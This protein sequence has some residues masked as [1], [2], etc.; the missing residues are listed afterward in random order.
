MLHF[1]MIEDGLGGKLGDFGNPK[2]AKK[3]A[4]RAIGC[5][6]DNLHIINTG[7]GVYWYNSAD[8]DA[9][10]WLAALNPERVVFSGKPAC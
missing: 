9:D 6:P 3:R 1:Y 10:Y 8:N 4:A 7:E 5:K 2:K